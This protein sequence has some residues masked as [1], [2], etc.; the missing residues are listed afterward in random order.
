[1]YFSN[2]DLK[3]CL[4]EFKEGYIQTLEED[5]EFLNKKRLERFPFL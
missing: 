2:E 4:E 5:L 3:E 1:M